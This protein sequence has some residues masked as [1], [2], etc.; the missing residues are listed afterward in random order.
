MRLGVGHVEGGDEARGWG[1]LG[2]ER[3]DEARGWVEER[4]SR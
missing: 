4:G 3:G 1:M 2:R